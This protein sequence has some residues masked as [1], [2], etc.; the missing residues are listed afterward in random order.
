[1]KTV[2]EIME[3]RSKVA[4]VCSFSDPETFAGFDTP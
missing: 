4:G 2:S 3:D 1:M